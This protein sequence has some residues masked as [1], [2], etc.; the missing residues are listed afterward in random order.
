VPAWGTLEGTPLPQGL[1]WVAEEQAY[2]FSL[3]SKHATAVSLLLYGR[4]D[5]VRPV[6][7]LG[8]D[9]RRNKSGR[10]WHCR[11]AKAAVQGAEHYA[12]RVSGPAPEGRLAWHCFDADKV[13]LDPYAASVHF[14]P[15]FDREAARR[16]GSNAGR[17]PLAVLGACE[18]PPPA[19]PAALRRHGSDAVICELHVRGFTSNPNSGIE[20][21]RRG[22][23]LGLVDKIPY[24]VDLG[25]TI[26]E[27]MPVFQCDPQEGS[28]WGYMP[29]NF[30]SPHS[31]YAGLHD[32]ERRPQHE[33]RAM[34]AAFASAGIEVV[35]D[36]VYN[37]T[38]E[39]GE[40]GPVYSYKGVDN[41]TYYL[42]SGLDGRRYED[43]SGAGNTL[44]CANRQVRRL[45]LDSMRHWAQE[46][47]SGFR[48]DLASVF[49]RA[50][51]G[52]VNQED[53]QL[54]GDIVSDPLLS[55]M[56][57]IAE[58][59]DTGAYQLGLPLP[60]GVWAQW[61]G[62]Y[63]DDLRR[64][65]RGEGGMVA[66]LMR[67]LYGSDD[68]FPDTLAASCR[69]GQS[70]NF[71][72]VHDGFTLYDLV[73]YDTKHNQANGGDGGG[74]D[75]NLSWNCGWEGDDGVPLAVRDLRRRQAKNLCCLLFLSNGTP[76]FRAGDEF[77]QTQGGNNNPYNQDNKTTWLDWDRLR[78]E[79]EHH[80]FFRLMLA[81]RTAHPS[82]GRS[83]FWRDDVRW[84]GVGPL[85]DL[86]PDSRSLAFRLAGASQRD[87][88]LYVMINAWWEP[89]DFVLQDERPLDWKRVIDTG[90][91]GPGDLLE[92][93]SEIPLQSPAYRLGP[94]S[95]AVFL[96][97]PRRAP[98]EPA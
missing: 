10:F 48:F 51:D 40:D 18:D 72:A 27:L 93:G 49:S 80:R 39:G 8:L 5:P 62:R 68:L 66:S 69:P 7:T 36:V 17:A 85:P 44:H 2:N 35:L 75:E 45:V 56:R 88:D 58:P 98:G 74:R 19:A 59:W 55:T 84:H 52:S 57:L 91:P 87:C 94:R 3:Y 14:P 30:F 82:L 4:G 33:F 34:V 41:S 46:G 6:L 73:A 1:T 37:H 21:S 11:L 76:L 38:C 25:V 67:R 43:F 12:Y 64:F 92:P 79:G 16:P 26:V 31:G 20:E 28:A 77:L 95:V 63:R 54:F 13:L 29:L 65:V 90:L 32:G 42:I 53:S 89:L 81:F 47:V 97:A 78:T 96:H 23:Y 83:H 71:A 9:P 24:L 22:T 61:N 50:L 60:G 70:V 15:G 86:G